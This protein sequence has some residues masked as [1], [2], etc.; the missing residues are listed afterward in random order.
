MVAVNRLDLKGLI[1]PL[2]VLRTQKVMRSLPN[3]AVI[4]VLATDPSTVKDFQA[5]C[6]ASGHILQDWH[7]VDGIFTFRIEKRA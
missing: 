5:F 1:C 2:P 4:E 7:E 6:E 3:T